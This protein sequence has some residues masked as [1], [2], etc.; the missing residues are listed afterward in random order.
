MLKIEINMFR[1]WHR[2]G[3]KY[4]TK[5]VTKSMV[6]FS[7]QNDISNLAN[8]KFY[9]KTFDSKVIVGL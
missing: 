5:N 6:N 7:V 3:V 4:L 2:I 1:V 9:L 8:I